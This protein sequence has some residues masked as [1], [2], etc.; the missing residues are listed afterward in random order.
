MNIKSE[1][2]KM[3]YNSS[4]TNYRQDRKNREEF[5]LISGRHNAEMRAAQNRA[6]ET[7][8]PA[9]RAARLPRAPQSVLRAGDPFRKAG[10]KDQAKLMDS[11]ALRKYEE[12]S[13]ARGDKAA[14]RDFSAR[15]AARARA[16]DLEQAALGRNFSARQAALG[17][18]ADLEKQRIAGN[19]IRARKMEAEKEMKLKKMH[20]TQQ[21]KL[22]LAKGNRKGEPL[23]MMKVRSDLFQEFYDKG[24]GGSVLRKR[25]DDD[26]DA[27]MSDVIRQFGQPSAQQPG[28]LPAAP[29]QAAIPSHGTITGRGGVLA[30][31][32][33]GRT[34]DAEQYAQS[35]LPNAPAVPQQQIEQPTGKFQYE[36]PNL[37]ELDAMEGDF[38]T[39]LRSGT[40]SR[41][42]KAKEFLSKSLLPEKREPRE[43][44][45]NITLK[46]YKKGDP[47]SSG[48]RPLTPEERLT[49]RQEKRKRVLDMFFK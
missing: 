46:K 22:A 19:R 31:S 4:P 39:Y 10:M 15:Q 40:Q 41:R 36:A 13:R 21:L 29:A 17:R 14:D 24:R 1:K 2:T 33:G 25:Y 45:K 18:A 11:R 8:H 27:Y 30:A 34:V 37:E 48:S 7:L 32:R 9:E 49:S 42:K 3:N 44:L 23:D 38:P 16:A 12:E 20:G 5:D 28:L 6:L 47:L 26:F 35:L 43:W